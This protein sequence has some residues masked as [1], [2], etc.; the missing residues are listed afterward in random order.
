MEHYVTKKGMSK[1]EASK[2]IAEWFQSI[3][4]DIKPE[5][6]RKKAQRASK[7]LGTNVPRCK[8]CGKNQ[9]IKSPKTKEPMPHGKCHPCRS[10]EIK[11]EKAKPK[12]TKN[13]PVINVSPAAEEFWIDLIAEVDKFFKRPV[14]G[15]VGADVLPKVSLMR[16][17]INDRVAELEK[18]STP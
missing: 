16:D 12:D 15:A 14:H 13:G 8:E 11:K 3:G 5:T 6:V 4:V 2:K 1:T 17:K 10:K 18:A 9:V 7:K